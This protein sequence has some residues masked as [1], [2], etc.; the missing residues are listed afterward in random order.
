MEVA[1]SAKALRIGYSSMQTGSG[2]VDR[3]VGAAEMT[4]GFSSSRGLSV[5]EV[6]LVGLRG[7][8]AVGS[9][10]AGWSM[11]PVLALSI[12]LPAH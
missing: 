5:R 7:N 9:Y 11:V 4:A 10:K 12:T 3:P 6:E 1:A 2:G 8:A